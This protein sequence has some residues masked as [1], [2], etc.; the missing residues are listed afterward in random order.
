MKIAIQ[1]LLLSV[2]FIFSSLIN[3]SFANDNVVKFKLEIKPNQ[4]KVEAKIDGDEHKQIQIRAEYVKLN[5]ITNNY[6]I[7]VTIINNS[8]IPLLHKLA[9]IDKI[10]H[11][12][13]KYPDSTTDYTKIDDGKQITKTLPYYNYG[14]I[15]PMQATPREWYISNTGKE[16][17]EVE[18]Y[19]ISKEIPVVLDPKIAAANPGVAET[20]TAY[21][22]GHVNNDLN[23]VLLVVAKPNQYSGSDLH[24]EYTDTYNNYPGSFLFSALIYSKPVNI[25]FT[26]SHFCT[27][28]YNWINPDD[29]SNNIWLLN[30][31]YDG[32]KWWITN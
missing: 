18:G 14:N 23:G 8:G 2:V 5:T 15:K 21:I 26:G 6:H 4:Q 28:R 13:V 11:S 20:L 10:E 19:I 1:I 29:G 25:G 30:L 22:Q 27:I 7:K 16:E 31:D 12:E 24:K 3:I 17:I 32:K 9:L